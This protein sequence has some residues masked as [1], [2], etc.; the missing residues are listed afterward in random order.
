MELHCLLL[1]CLPWVFLCWPP[2]HSHSSCLASLR[3][4]DCLHPQPTKEKISQF[5]LQDKLGY[6]WTLPQ[7][8]CEK[9]IQLTLGMG[10]NWGRSLRS[11]VNSI[12]VA[13]EHCKEKGQWANPHKWDLHGQAPI[14][15]LGSG[16]RVLRHQESFK[17]HLSITV[18][19]KFRDLHPEMNIGRRGDV[20]TGTGWG[21]RAL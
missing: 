15:V 9:P 16:Q 4:D 8:G 12:P 20:P 3:K 19:D 5:H 7:V 1:R 21:P 2:N 14:C 18:T 11:M 17:C 6:T 13:V 10:K